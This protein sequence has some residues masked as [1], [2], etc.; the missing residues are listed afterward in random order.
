M[1]KKMDT[2]TLKIE[3]IIV[4]SIPWHKKDD[5]SIKP[6]YSEQESNLSDGLRIFFK[7]KIINS[8]QSNKELRVCYNPDNVSPVPTNINDILFS[9]GSGLVEQSKAI[10]KYLYESQDG[11]NSSGILVVVFG[12][13]SECNTCIIMKLEKDEGAQLELDESTKSYNI[14]D[15]HNLMLTS[16]TKLYKVGL[17]ID[18]SDLE[19]KYDGSVADLQIDPKNK[20][21]VTTWFIERFLGCIPLEDPRITTKKFY[22]YTTTFIQT[23]EDPVK[24]AKYTQDLNSYLQ[25]NAK[26]FSA[27]E[28]SDNHFETEDKDSYK[29][30]LLGKDFRTSSFPKDIDYVKNKIKS[31]VMTFENNIS[32][33]GKKGT[34]EKNVKLEN[35]ENGDIKAEII[36]KVKSIK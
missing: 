7:D 20:K 31:I 9:D 33:V 23:I 29:N 34:F 1:A 3:R 36:S 35:Q 28:F 11:Q 18:K 17:F 5:F 32:I 10:A 27:K 24:K 22:E 13:I 8:L 19:V 26:T 14:V 4:H 25:S 15:V 6:T 2:G 30:Y 12:S 21:E 16:K